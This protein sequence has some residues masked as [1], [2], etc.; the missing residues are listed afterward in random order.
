[1]ANTE[2]IEAKLCAYVDGEL[3]A[4]GRADIEAHLQANP[5]HRQ[6]LAE[7]IEQRELLRN[8]PREKAPDDLAESFQ[9]QLERSVL[10]NQDDAYIAGR[11]NRW[12]PIVAAAVLLLSVGL[13]TIIYFILPD[14]RNHSDYA[15][16]VTTAPIPEGAASETD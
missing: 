1:M 7:L 9:T 16:M 2:N 5:Q 6:L 14:Q 13:V 8:L 10:F 4:A 3:D 15:R 11:I 12:P